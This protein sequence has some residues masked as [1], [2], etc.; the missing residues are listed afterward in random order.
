MVLRRKRVVRSFRS[1]RLPGPP[2][3]A[4]RPR[5][6][7]RPGMPRLWLRR[8]QGS[9]VGCFFCDSFFVGAS[10]S[11]QPH[12]FAKQVETESAR[13]GLTT[14]PSSSIR[15][16]DLA[17]SLEP[18]APPKFK[19]ATL[20][21]A[22]DIRTP[23]PQL[24]LGSGLGSGP[25]L[26]RPRPRHRVEAPLG[27]PSRLVARFFGFGPGLR[28]ASRPRLDRRCSATTRALQAQTRS[29]AQAP[30][31]C[32]CVCACACCAFAAFSACLSSE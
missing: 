31:V 9:S 17:A 13:V 16:G 1:G 30:Q 18:T 25:S 29:L 4:R 3:V 10:G 6:T 11:A 2:L 32:C 24:R 12:P 22:A 23:I 19:F 15:N 8:L 28:R 26:A 20:Q 21:A 5:C 14:P 27:G 7:A